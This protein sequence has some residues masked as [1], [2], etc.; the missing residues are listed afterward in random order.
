[1]SKNRHLAV[2]LFLINYIDIYAEQQHLQTWTSCIFSNT[3]NGW[4]VH[5]GNLLQ[6]ELQISQ[7]RLYIEYKD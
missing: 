2:R 6:A 4:Q 5:S 7:L 1:M 3:A